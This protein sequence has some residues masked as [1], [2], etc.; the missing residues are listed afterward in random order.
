MSAPVRAVSAER[1]RPALGYAM[2]WASATLFAV[3]GTVSKVLLESG[4]SSSRL[5]QLRSTGA[6][7]GLLLA[8]AVLRPRTLRVRRDELP[9]LVAF[10]LFGVA[11][12]QWTYFAAIDRLPIGIAL[13]IQ[14]TAPLLV[15]IFGHFVLHRPVRRRLWLAL[16][17]ALAGLALVVEIWSGLA[18]D[19]LGLAAA[20]GASLS[21][22][23]YLLLAERELERRDPVSLSAYGFG[24]A[25]LLWAVVLPWWS[26]PAGVLGGDRSLLGN[27]D[28]ASAPGWALVFWLLVPGTI[29]PFVLVVGALRHTAST[30]VAILAM[31]EPVLGALVAWAWLGQELA[32]AQ[33]AGG[34]LVLA[35]IVLAQTASDANPP[36]GG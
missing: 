24:V 1:R 22:A 36:K 23:T 10:G 15:A 20:A 6:A 33:L 11:L 32:A 27:L 21:Y 18:L 17:L 13:L 35:A 9:A 34:A 8:V 26:F 28:A 14:F 3:N 12:V 5:T 31:L 4:L 29:L 16:A 30:R 2:V 19:G 25:A 7:V